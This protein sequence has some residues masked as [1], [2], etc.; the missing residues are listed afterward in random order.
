[1]GDRPCASNVEPDRQNALISRAFAATEKY[2]GFTPHLASGSTDCNIPLSMGI[3]SIM[4]SCGLGQG[5]HT[6]EE[7][8]EIASQI[9]GLKIAFEMI[10]HYF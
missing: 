3:P 9:P 8:F 7:Y 5:A 6:R 10:L 2:L 1:M 4:V